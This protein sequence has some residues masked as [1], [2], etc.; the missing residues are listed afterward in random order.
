M[1]LTTNQRSSGSRAATVVVASGPSCVMSSSSFRRTARNG[2][3][4][5]RIEQGVGS[6][7]SQ[8]RNQLIHEREVDRRLAERRPQLFRGGEPTPH[9]RRSPARVGCVRDQCQ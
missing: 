1:F 3:R 8:S 9:G 4:L 2:E 5:E 6:A 7:Q